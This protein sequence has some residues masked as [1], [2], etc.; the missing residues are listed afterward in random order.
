MDAKV[1]S[2]GSGTD[3]PIGSAAYF[4]KGSLMVMTAQAAEAGGLNGGSSGGL[5]VAD[6]AKL[7]LV[8]AKAGRI[9]TL[10]R[11]FTSTSHSGSGWLDNNFALSNYVLS[12]TGRFTS[13]GYTL[14]A[15]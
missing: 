7:S 14:K 11:G 4:G 5:T 12:G 10:A 9:Y 3:A 1:A 2:D 13:D 15:G 8:N 6:G